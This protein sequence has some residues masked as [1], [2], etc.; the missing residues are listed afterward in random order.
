MSAS[1]ARSPPLAWLL[2]ACVEA[3]VTASWHTLGC[4]EP[5][6][7]YRLPPW[8]EELSGSDRPAHALRRWSSADTARHINI[9][10]AKTS[11]TRVVDGIGLSIGLDSCVVGA[12][13]RLDNVDWVSL[14]CGRR[15]HSCRGGEE[16]AS[17]WPRRPRLR[18]HC[19]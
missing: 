4:R 18:L 3:T 15:H 2:G 7:S 9:R 8:H 16:L 12:P 11:C 5:S 19:G 17:L 14:P 1:S 13:H 6:D 10:M